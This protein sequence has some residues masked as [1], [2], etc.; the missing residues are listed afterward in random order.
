MNSKNHST[1]DESKELIDILLRVEKKIDRLDKHRDL[2]KDYLTTQEAC[3]YLG[4]TRT[5]VWW[6]VQAG[7][8]TK[9]KLDNGRTYYASQELKK[10]VESPPGEMVA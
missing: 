3:Y 5:M 7:K 8:L 4:C 9:L 6:L 1:G 2:N 10:L